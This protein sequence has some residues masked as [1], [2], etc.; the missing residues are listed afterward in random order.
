MAPS[1]ELVMMVMMV[2]KMMVMK[3]KIRMMRMRM[4]M[5][6]MMG[7]DDDDDDNDAAAAAVEEEEKKKEE[8]EGD[9]EE[10][11]L[12]VGEVPGKASERVLRVLPRFTLG[13]SAERTGRNP[14]RRASREEKVVQHSHTHPTSITST[15]SN[16]LCGSCLR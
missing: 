2:M 1:G 8:E 4:L 6:V 14:L 10:A 9:E 16:G 11:D 3:K 13:A 15:G 7:D 12:D 5:R